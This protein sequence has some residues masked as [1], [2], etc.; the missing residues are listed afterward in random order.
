VQP[1]LACLAFFGWSLSFRT[2]N[3]RDEV[4]A[5]SGVAASRSGAAASGWIPGRFFA[6]Q[7]LRVC[8]AASLPPVSI[9]A[10][11]S[12][13]G[14]A[15]GFSA[16]SLVSG[17]AFSASA[18]VVGWGLGFADDVVALVLDLA[19]GRPRV[20]ACVLACGGLL[21]AAVVVG[22]ALAVCRLLAGL[23]QVTEDYLVARLSR[24]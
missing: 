6:L 14:L 8:A 3:L 2:S 5:F 18:S 11:E 4:V 17:A 15:C 20:V 22:V 16:R 23:L 12:F 21:A 7:R 1:Q 13:V 10:W 19:S 24:S 9:V